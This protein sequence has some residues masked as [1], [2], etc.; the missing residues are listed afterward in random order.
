MTNT[1][2]NDIC[3][4]HVHVVGPNER[5]P[6]SEGRLYTAGLATPEDLQAVAL[7]VGVGRY[8]L[9]QPSFYGT[10][11]SYVL[12]SLDVL[13]GRGRAVVVIDPAAT[14]ASDWEALHKRGARGARLNLYSKYNPLAPGGLG[15][16]LKRFTD[17]MP[18]SGWHIEVIAS[19]QT[20]IESASALAD[21]PIPIVLDHYGLPG[22][23]K[24]DGELGRRMLNLLSLPHVWMKLSAPYRT[25]ND[26][27]ATKPPSEWLPALVRVA[28]D[29]CVWGSD[30]PFPPS[31]KNQTGKDVSLPYRPIDYQRTLEDFFSALPAAES[32]MI[33][34]DNPARLYGFRPNQN[35][36]I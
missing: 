22:D 16:V 4:S 27:L 30:W 7:P 2:T 10:N 19:F 34:R 23:E 8:V 18:R 11:N 29:R 33:L 25:G 14:C 20:V 6:Q 35:G 17:N 12:E 28:P 32:D 26:P 13:K 24:P 15:D 9:V 1:L 5:Y 21:S 36:N 3:D 31:R